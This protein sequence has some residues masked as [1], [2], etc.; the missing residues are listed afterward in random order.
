[1]TDWYPA[2]RMGW[3]AKAAIGLG[4]LAVLLSRPSRP[5]FSSA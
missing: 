4:V 5:R 1:M 2:R 3:Q